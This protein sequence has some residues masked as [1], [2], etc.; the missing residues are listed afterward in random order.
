M[1]VKGVLQCN[2]TSR[3]SLWNEPHNEVRKDIRCG[4]DVFGEPRDAQSRYRC[5]SLRYQVECSNRSEEVEERGR[6]EA[7]A[8]AGVQGRSG[9][10]RGKKRGRPAIQ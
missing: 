3:L 2:G 4:R 6:S 9:K 8:G 7:E 1:M 10:S 5:K